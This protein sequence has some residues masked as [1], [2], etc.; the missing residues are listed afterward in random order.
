MN[1]FP[2]ATMDMWRARV[3]A[4]LKGESADKLT[5]HTADGIRIEPLY[6]QMR[7]E[8]AERTNHAPWTVLQRVDHPN[9]GKANAQALEDLENGAGGL[10]IVGKDADVTRALKGV[11]LHAIHTRLEGGETL[12]KTFADYVGKQPI[13]P[14]RL[15]VSFG[16][17][18][19]GLVNELVAQGFEGPFLEA[20]GRLVHTQGASEAQELACI[21]AQIV[22]ALR[23]LEQVPPE[24]AVGATL[25]A[26]QDMFL[27][28]AKF[29]AIRLLWARVLEASGILHRPLRLH[30]ETSR[31]MM[32]RLDPHTNILRATAAVFGAGLGGTDTFTVLPFSIAQGLPDAFA[33]RMARNTQLILLEESHLWCVADPA[34]GSGYVEHLTDELCERAWTIFQGIEKT[35]NLPEFDSKNKSSDPIIGTNSHHLPK[36]FEAAVEI[37]P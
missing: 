18:D 17:S 9:G 12:A 6:Q 27:N 22:S 1:D 11:A 26:N 5:S 23:K 34:S 33:R 13:D 36:E 28:L 25:V 37:F 7:G 30:G 15:S 31:R 8:R 14:A 20:D 32:A 29:R 16:L 35:G 21:L 24:A 4:V 10:A 2:E 19:V 3:T